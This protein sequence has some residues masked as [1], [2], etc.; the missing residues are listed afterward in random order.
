MIGLPERFVDMMRRE[1]GAEADALFAALDSRSEVSYRFNPAKTSAAPLGGEPIGWSEHGRYLDGRPQFTLDPALHAGAYYVQEPSS[2]FVRHI[3]RGER[4]DGAR[5]LDMCAAPGGKTTIYSSLAGRHGI[6]VAN[7]VN[8]NRAL[9]LADNV[10]RWGLGNVV[11]TCNEAQH[12]AAFE[13]WFD[14]VAVDAPCSGEGM[15][16]KTEEAR[17]EWSESA[18]AMCAERQRRIVAEAWRTLRAGGVFIYST[19]TFNRTENEGVVEWIVRQW[20]DDIEPAADVECPPQWGV[21]HSRLGAFQT[22]RFYPHRLRG[23]GFFVAVAR[24]KGGDAGRRATVKARRSLFSTPDR[25]S[26]IELGRWVR[27]S[28]DMLFRCVGDTVYAYRSSHFDDIRVISEALSVVCSGVAMGR[29]F[30]GSL[31]PDH[32]LALFVDFDRDAVPCIEVSREEALSY[33]RRKDIPAEGFAQGINAVVC[34]GLP[35]GFVKRTGARCNNMYPKDLRI[36]KN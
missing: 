13:R 24:K 25:Q 29:I 2:Q 26:L 3:L 32:A 21:E 9:V 18:V 36:I 19:C 35:I 16:R 34:G 4:L 22:F 33:L 6:V 12:V 27:C 14:V 17:G 8:R 23:E 5:I 30:K 31:R 1:M 20:G 10:R 7:E 28:D 11:V 15:F